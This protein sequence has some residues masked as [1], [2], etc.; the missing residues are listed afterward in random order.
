[1]NNLARFVVKGFN[2]ETKFSKQKLIDKLQLI[3]M[4]DYEFFSQVTFSQEVVMHKIIP[5]LK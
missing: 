3:T 1:M 5:L 4:N 2:R